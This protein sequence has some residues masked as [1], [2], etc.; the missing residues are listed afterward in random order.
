M[1]FYWNVCCV[2]APQIL[3]LE[4]W[5]WGWRDVWTRPPTALA[6]DPSSG[7][8]DTHVVHRHKGRQNTCAQKLEWWHKRLIPALPRQRC[9]EPWGLMASQLCLIF[10]L[11]ANERSCLI[12]NPYALGQWEIL[13]Q[14][15]RWWSIVVTSA[16]NL[17]TPDAE[18]GR[19]EFET[20]LRG[21]HRELDQI[22]LH[23]KTLSCT[24]HKKQNKTK[25]KKVMGLVRWLSG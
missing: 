5:A 20:P 11:W 14:K 19:F 1:R 4:S 9:D 18:T 12:P 25:Q 15:T 24:Q 10:T 17:S 16:F 3:Q 22:E 8:S 7:G 21:L 2:A 23:G 13:S 6:E